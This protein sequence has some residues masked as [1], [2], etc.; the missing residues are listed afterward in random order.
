MHVAILT[1]TILL[2]GNAVAQQTDDDAQDER[3]SA[4][5]YLDEIVVTGR[6]GTSEQTKLET[7]Y[8][9]TT[10]TAADFREFAPLSAT[11]FLK[12]V[13]GFWVEASGGESNGNVRARGI[14]LD[15]FATIGLYEDGLPLQHDPGISW[16]N[17]DQ[18]LRLDETIERVEVVRGGPSVIFASNAPGGLV[19]FVTKK[20][21]DDPGGVL[22]YTVGDY[23]M[24]RVDFFYDGP[25]TDEWKVAFGGYYR[26][27]D[28]I[29]EPGFTANAGG[30]LRFTLSREFE[31][32]RLDVSV[33]RLDDKT[34]FA[35]PIP[36][37]RDASGD[38]TDV[39]GFDANTGTTLG[40]DVLNFVM[41]T[42][43]GLREFDLSRGTDVDLTAIT[44][45]F[46][47]RFADWTFS[48]N[49]RYRDSDV[50]RN[51]AFPNT[52]LA[53]S[54][55]LTAVR[56]DALAAF[57]GAVDVLLQYAG[58]GASFDLVNQNGNGLV[59]T[60]NYT[61]VD[62]PLRE[63]INEV[64]L[65]RLIE[66]GS[67]THDISFG[68]YFA[69][70]DREFD[71]FAS[72]YL[73]EVRGAP[74][75]LDILAVDA[76]GATVGSV[77]DNGGVIR[78]GARFQQADDEAQVWAFYVTDEWQ[79]SERFR[80]DAGLRWEEI[81]LRGT[82]QRAADFDLGDPTT[83]AD[84]SVSFGNGIFEP[85]DRSFDDIAY[86]IGANFKITDDASV[87]GRY[88]DSVLLPAT[89]DFNLNAGRQVTVEEVTMVEVGYKQLAESFSLFATAFFTNFEN[90]RFEN[91]T[92]DPLTGSFVTQVQFADTETFGLEFEGFW[93]PVELFELSATFTW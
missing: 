24:Q 81:D 22:K 1:A 64:R 78:Y 18:V 52:P 66:T 55:Q 30:Q 44:V 57:P 73:T 92:V 2:G 26:R 86:S 67:Q 61:S 17:A 13:P 19:N 7:S 42:P 3:S 39:P 83:L 87:F 14:P 59:M 71:R 23:D 69:T 58:S 79:I 46:E 80:L 88:T 62:V 32:G 45:N 38:V 72:L 49:F 16:L 29:R 15:G 20:G 6:A 40:P 5:L 34:F 48:N 35:L 47:K 82:A 68:V 53:A 54:D 89:S 60:S 21:T 91:T 75:N 77:T 41:K 50:L 84:D 25:L 10:K 12:S 33:R 43:D 85:F 31:D 56:S 70:Y 51:S 36:V 90:I 9:I 65:S 93:A 74:R 28:G 76:T 4:G 63:A 37:T 27:D 11:D 8:A